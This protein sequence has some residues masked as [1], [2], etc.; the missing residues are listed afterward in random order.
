MDILCKPYTT[1]YEPIRDAAG[2]VIGIYYVGYMNRA[3][4]GAASLFVKP[5]SCACSGT[6]LLHRDKSYSLHEFG[7][8]G[9]TN[10]SLRQQLGIVVASQRPVASAERAAP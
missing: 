3:A 8:L 4:A 6:S 10:R 5:T 1:G 7:S 9:I 2:N